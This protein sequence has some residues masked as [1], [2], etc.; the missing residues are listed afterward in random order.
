MVS[1]VH[2]NAVRPR[3]L[4]LPD[5]TTIVGG[6]VFTRLTAPLMY[7]R[8]QG[9]P[10]DWMPWQQARVA[11]ALHKMRVAQYDVFVLQRAGDVDGRTIAFCQMLRKAGK[12]VI[13][14]GDDDYTNEY[15]VVLEADAIGV[16]DA[17]TALTVSTPRLRTQMAKRVSRPIY[18]L[19]NCI[20]L[21]Y[22]DS[23]KFT[24]IVPSPSVGLVGTPSH[25]DDWQAVCTV[26]ERIGKERPEV[27][28]AVG[29]MF[30]EYLHDLPNLHHLEPCPYKAYPA[31]VAQIDIGLAPLVPDDPFNWSK[32]G[33]KAM[34]YWCA[35]AP[36]V[37]SN[38]IPYQRVVD[39][40]R[41][42]LVDHND[43]D[44]WYERIITYLDNP[45]LR[46]QHASAGR[47]WVRKNRSMERNAILWWA[48][49]EEVYK[50]YG[51]QHERIIS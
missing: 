10:V 21:R 48:V 46:R 13:W 29:G 25:Y 43:P 8:E 50:K 4:A 41:G 12:I 26:L 15:R 31:M 51:G 39:E 11:A 44:A 1:G 30:P 42:F 35:G 6:V 23:V 36:V 19:Q 14:E 49:Y 3:V 47:E 9:Y 2:A 7:L 24:R 33:I 17:C 20:D 16:A 22:W 32:S 37:A 18:L 40:D 28:F 38:A 5:E 34:E 27:H 45:G